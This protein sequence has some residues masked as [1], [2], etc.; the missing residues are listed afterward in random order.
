MAA[1]AWERMPE[2]GVV[3]DPPGSGVFRV[4]FP[5]DFY[6]ANTDNPALPEYF[7]TDIESTFAVN[8]LT[9]EANRAQAIRDYAA[10]NGFTVATNGI[11]LDARK[12]A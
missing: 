2:G 5:V 1:R 12:Q 8:L 4:N 7:R 10:A 6:Q 11:Y 9:W 3:E